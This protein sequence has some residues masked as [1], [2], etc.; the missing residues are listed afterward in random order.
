MEEFTSGRIWE[1]RVCLANH[2]R[3]EICYALPLGKQFV[4]T[5]MRERAVLYRIHLNPINKG[6]SKNGRK[7]NGTKGLGKEDP[8]LRRR[9]C[10]MS[11]LKALCF[12]GTREGDT[13][14]CLVLRRAIYAWVDL[15]SL[16]GPGKSAINLLYGQL[17]VYE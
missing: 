15:D 9:I 12:K 17:Y 3:E 7:L 16:D 10:R 2:L 8:I 13:V 5:S 11:S 6:E 1:G 4:S 14:L